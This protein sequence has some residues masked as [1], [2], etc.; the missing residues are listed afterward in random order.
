MGRSAGSRAAA[1]FRSRA[2]VVDADIPLFLA[3]WQFPIYIMPLA[4]KPVFKRWLRNP[5]RRLEA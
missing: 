5:E 2:A 1:D 4:L 3:L